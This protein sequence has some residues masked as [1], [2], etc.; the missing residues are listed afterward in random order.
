M[1]TYVF[2]NHFEA[3]VAAVELRNDG[4]AVEVYDDSVAALW[5]PMA[6]GGVRLV[7]DPIQDRGSF[8]ENELLQ[9]GDGPVDVVFRWVFAFVLVGGGLSLLLSLL[10]DAASSPAKLLMV[11]VLTGV[12]ALGCIGVFGL[13]A[14]FTK[15]LF[16]YPLAMGLCASVLLL[17]KLFVG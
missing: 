15:K 2:S 4:Y 8:G 14:E 13:I 6:V 11:L 12:S 5:G 1:K 9:V 17:A 10:F 7:V 16:T 3:A